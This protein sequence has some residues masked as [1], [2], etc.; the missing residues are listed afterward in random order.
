MLDLYGF[1]RV[2]EAAK[3]WGF[4]NPC[5][6]KSVDDLPGDVPLFVVRA[7]QDKIPH[8]NEVMD[9]FLA[10]ALARNLPIT[11]VNYA[12]APHAFDL[13]HDSETT[14]DI[15]RQILAFMRFHLLT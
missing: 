13:M 8:L 15:I 14:R 5:S 6:G 2:A 7:G 9:T 4:V 3:L 10:T 1:A 11:L 12:G